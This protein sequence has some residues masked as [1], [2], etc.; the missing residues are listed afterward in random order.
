MKKVEAKGKEKIAKLNDT[1]TKNMTKFAK[2]EV[3]KNVVAKIEK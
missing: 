2:S 3:V 1:K